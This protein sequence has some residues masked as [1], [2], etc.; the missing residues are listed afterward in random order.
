MDSSIVGFCRYFYIPVIQNIFHL[1]YVSII[2]TYHYRNTCLDP[3]K[4]YSYFPYVLLCRDFAERVL[5]RFSRQI[6][7]E[8]YYV[9]R[10]MYIEGISLEHLSAT[11]Q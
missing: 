10:Y 1:P 11:E 4:S 7:Y 2:W 6:Q 9:N 5:S 8:Y 3:F